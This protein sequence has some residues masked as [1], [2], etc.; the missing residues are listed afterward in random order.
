MG[1]LS[2]F[3]DAGEKL[4]NLG[5]AK[6]VA[7]APTEANVEE[8]Q[9]SAVQAIQAY[10]AT[11]GIATDGLTFAFDAASSTVTV[12][13]EAPDQATREK[14]V[15]CCGNVHGVEHVND[16]LTVAAPADESQWYTVVSGDNLSKI[17]K[18]FYGDPNKYPVIFEAN[19]PMLSSPDKIYP[20]Q[21]LRIP[22]LT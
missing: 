8:L 13:G 4:L 1:L 11:Q 22:A 17:S 2:F 21:M 7:A 10:I 18:Q 12:G 15:L 3:K 19:K 5:K 9:N 16:E 14:I 20:G 6:E